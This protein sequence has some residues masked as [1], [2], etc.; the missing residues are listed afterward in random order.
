MSDAQSSFLPWLRRGITRHLVAPAAGATRASI[1]VVLR[2][3]QDGGTPRDVQRAMQLAGPGDVR[4]L[5][6]RSVRRTWPRPDV[7]DAEPNLLALVE[8]HQCDLPWRFTPEAPST[9]GS[10]AAVPT[11]QLRPWMCLVVLEE[12][13]FRLT[14]SSEQQPFARL[15]VTSAAALPSLADSWAWAH[16]QY[17]GDVALSPTAASAELRDHPDRF[18]SRLVC[19]RR[20]KPR[21]TYHGFVVPSFLRGALAGLGETVPADVAPTA[22]A[23]PRPSGA[24]PQALPVYHQWRFGTGE[25]GDFESLVRALVARRLPRTVGTRSMRVAVDGLGTATSPVPLEAALEPLGAIHPDW[26]TLA[27][28]TFTEALRDLLNRP[29]VELDRP[30]PAGVLRQPVVPPTYGQWPALRDRLGAL[31]A[32]LIDA[33]GWLAE[34]N[35][36]P[37]HRSAGGMG[38]RVV[39]QL[40]QSLMASAWAQLGDIQPINETLRFGQLSRESSRQMHRRWLVTLAASPEAVVLFTTAVHGQVRTSDG[41]VYGALRQSPIDPAVLDP[42]WRRLTRRGGALMWRQD[43]GMERRPVSF[44]ARMNAGDLIAERALSTPTGVAAPANL[45]GPQGALPFALLGLLAGLPSEG[46][47]SSGGPA[48]RAFREAARD[49]DKKKRDPR[50]GDLG[51]ILGDLPVPRG[52]RVFP[53][54]PDNGQ[55][56]GGL[57]DAGPEAA[58]AFNEA[59]AEL[60]TVL[61]RPAR[62]GETLVPADLG[63]LAATLVT[64]LDPEETVTAALLGRLRFSPRL[65]RSSPDRLAP[66]MAAPEFEQPM[67]APLRA[68][69]QEWILPGLEDVPNNTATTV[70]TNRRFMEAYMVGLN[71]EMARE[72]LWNGYPT[73]RRGS[74]FRQFWEP[75]GAADA[76]G[77][78]ASPGALKDI[79]PLDAWAGSSPLG[80][81]G[82]RPGEANH[83]VL[84]VRSDLLR[85]YPNTVIYAATG[86]PHRGPAADAPRKPPIF[87]G[88]L[89]PD[90]TFLGF[91]LRPE[92]LAGTVLSDSG[93]AQAWFFVFEEQ[94]AEFRFGLDV[95][96]STANPSSADQLAWSQFGVAEGALLP[97]RGPAAGQRGLED[98]LLNANALHWPSAGA[99]RVANALFQRRVKVAIPASCMLPR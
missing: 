68:L 30:R 5:D 29:A 85:R 38:T 25:D 3:T 6:G 79:Q 8:F 43:R 28:R 36:D 72:L 52:F 92:D 75:V 83:V 10:T 31:P 41:T 15:E 57:V 82:V 40:Q 35:V 23:W 91:D 50:P 60:F 17:F 27:P 55:A 87:Q 64:S 49:K 99:E 84:L 66:V 44:L 74:Y 19:P 89:P 32:D 46:D 90:V 48:W 98:V 45:G 16:V 94:V 22:P 61:G 2:V 34:L 88:T 97:M 93:E 56:S 11:G 42:A 96:A 26:S 24:G 81:H 4:G 69:S 53:E 80:G 86:L 39:Q 1:D 70:Q 54:R 51:E 47:G 59:F 78:P 14:P 67:Y 20:L 65:R 77:R 12:S 21:T 7:V 62:P 73:D 33:A 37:R 9:A 71:H 95:T 58:Q 13:E 76:A 63:A 18:V